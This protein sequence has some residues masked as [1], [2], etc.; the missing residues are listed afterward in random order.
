MSRLRFDIPVSVVS[1]VALAFGLASPC[2][3][4][5]VKVAVAANFTAPAKEIA[6]AY[7]TQTGDTVLLSFGSSG[8]LY[9][10]ISQGAPFGIF[11]SADAKRPAK[12]EAEG[13]GVPGSSF[14]Y[15]VG[16]SVLWSTDANLVDADGA[17]LN[18]GNF[19]HIAIANP[20]AAPYGAAAVEAMTALGVYDALKDKI[21]MGENISQTFQFVQSGNAE[22]GF[23]AR[24]QIANAGGS[25][26]VVPTDLYTPILQDAVLLKVGADNETAKAFLD[27]LKGPEA[28][29]IIERYGYGLAGK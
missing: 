9:A 20:E 23:V 5:E 12:A 7:E 28:A 27:Y 21:V 8:A 15:A 14:T 26:W 18:A 11:L 25:S 2:F 16:Q 17:V 13:L 10:Q 29:E 4:G 22:I 1:F 19:V 6:A 24:S 3:S